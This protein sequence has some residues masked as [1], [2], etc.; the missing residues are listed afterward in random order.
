M[1]YSRRTKYIAVILLLVGLT[2]VCGGKSHSQQ[3]WDKISSANF[4]YY[5][6]GDL[7]PDADMIDCALKRLEWFWEFVAPLWDFPEDLRISYYKHA[8]CEELRKTTG[9]CTN[10]LAM[11]NKGI[12]HTVNLADSHEVSH[13]LTTQNL[14][15]NYRTCRLSNFWLEGIAMYYTWPLV[16]F[17]RGDNPLHEYLIGTWY[18]RTVHCH[19]KGLLEAGKLPEIRSSIYG[20]GYFDSLDVMESYPAAG[21][22]ITYLMGPAHIDMEAFEVFKEFIHRINTA[23]SDVE[24]EHIFLELF[25]ASLE[26][27]ESSWHRFLQDWCEGEIENYLN[28]NSLPT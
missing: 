5:Y 28:C 26:E 19:A 9:R 25:G 6:R 24:V 4:D 20:N 3:D 21:S 23:R 13:L 1:T 12:I 7:E 27:T 15:C 10:G 16:Y 14:F 8:S 2:L 22:F 17:C 11:L 18:S